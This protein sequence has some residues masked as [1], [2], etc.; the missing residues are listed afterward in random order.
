MW[1]KYRGHL[2]NFSHICGIS[3]DG[4]VKQNAGK[5]DKWYVRIYS[6]GKCFEVF[7]FERVIERDTCFHELEQIVEKLNQ[8]IQ[9]N[10]EEL[11]N[12]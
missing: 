8:G 3:A 10:F 7:T 12:G 5:P 2:F 6:S 4:P 9:L 1:V 11:L